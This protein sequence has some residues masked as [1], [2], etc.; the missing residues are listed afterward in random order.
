MA[1][2]PSIFKVMLLWHILSQNKRKKYRLTFCL[3]ERVISFSF[4][5]L[6]FAGKV[7]GFCA[8][9]ALEHHVKEVLKSPERIISPTSLVKNLTCILL[10]CFLLYKE[11]W[12]VQ[13]VFNILSFLDYWNIPGISR[14][15]R[16]W[17][18]EDAHEYMRYLI[19]ALR[20]CSSIELPIGETFIQSVFGGQLRSQV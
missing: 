8:M 18:Q 11:R 9:C 17:R 14:S 15:F 6:F 10:L 5:V 16:M 7:A 12:N 3:L 2:A 13:K 1:H 19:E 20:N 4:V